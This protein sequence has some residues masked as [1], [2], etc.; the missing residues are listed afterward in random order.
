MCWSRLSVMV[1]AGL[2]I[3]PVAHEAAAAPVTAAT[4][5]I[6]PAVV[7]GSITKIYYYHG[8]YY[9]YYYRGA[10]YP[11]RYGGHYYQ[12]RYYRYGHWRYY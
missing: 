12:H 2:L 1:V 10:Y 6:T 9:P 11:Y 8:R 7:D 4:P 3:V 5:R